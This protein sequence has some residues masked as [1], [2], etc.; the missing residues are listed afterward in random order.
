MVAALSKMF[1]ARNVLVSVL[2]AFTFI[3]STAEGR[4]IRKS[5]L[6]AKQL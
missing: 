3:I 5:E 6:H 4:Q 1:G 2:V